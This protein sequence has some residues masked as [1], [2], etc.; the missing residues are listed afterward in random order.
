[1]SKKE[2]ALKAFK[3]GV[4]RLSSILWEVYSRYLKQKSTKQSNLTVVFRR[5][6]TMT[7]SENCSV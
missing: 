4:W 7:L 5:F 3:I 2:K 6:C 1:M